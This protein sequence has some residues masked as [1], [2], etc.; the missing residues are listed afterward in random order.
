MGRARTG[1]APRYRL[2]D[3]IGK[4]G[5]E[6]TYDSALR[7]GNGERAVVVDSRG[8]LV[9]EYGRR[10]A[11]PGEPLRLTIDL[12]LQQAAER[13]MRGQVGAVVAL[14]PR[15]GAIRAMV[16]NPSYDPNV[17]ARGIRPAQWREL[18]EDEHDPL[19][20]RAIQ[21][22]HPPGSVF[23]IFMAAAGLQEGVITPA[24]RVHCSGG[25]TIYGR[26]FKCWR[27][28]GH[29]SVDLR[30]ALAQSCNVYFYLLGK[31]LGIE[32]I[33][34]YSK[35]FGLGERTGIELSGEVTGLV[36]SPEWSQRRRGHQWFPG[37]TISVA[38]GQGLLNVT[39]I[40]V[41]ASTA[42]IANGGR[43]VVPHL[44]EGRGDD[45]GR[46][47]VPVDPRHLE[48]VREGMHGVMSP[49]GTAYWRAHIEGI[50]SAGKTGTAQVAG[51]LESDN[52]DRPWRLRNHGWFTS[53][54]PLDSPELVVVVLAEHGGGGSVAAAPVAKEV[55]MEYFDI[56]ERRKAEAR[57]P[58]S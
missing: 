21:N 52:E 37:E 49:G 13:A 17:F 42:A 27:A 9:R 32:R 38:I 46:G 22:A 36:P 40:Q 5:V 12:D 47:R 28:G 58:V 45:D 11:D 23:K 25:T 35:A 1:E 19:Q 14:D 39:P 51:G 16:S 31:E 7:G 4:K 26:R 33:A 18:L 2:G 29:G 56:L 48:V 53:F 6:Q 24:S 30:R 55:Y 20:N 3:L 41:A 43:L 34:R 57:G 54:A 15:N 10:E 44:V 50:E 8:M